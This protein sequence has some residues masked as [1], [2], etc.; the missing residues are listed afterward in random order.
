MKRQENTIIGQM[1]KGTY[2]EHVVKTKHGDFKVKYP[3]GKETDL[4]S[5]LRAQALNGLPLES[6]DKQSIGRYHV[7][8]TLE[9]VIIE[10]PKDF[11]EVWQK[12]KIGDFPDQG[13]KNDIFNEFF[14]F[15]D[16]T[17]DSIS[18]ES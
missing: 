8:A 9:V 1:L 17:Q 11:P 14:T 10:Y 5:R 12:N 7:D 2:P 13:V 15:R 16:E 4:I 6:F 3:T 18:K